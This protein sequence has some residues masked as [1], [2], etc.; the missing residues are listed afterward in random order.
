MIGKT[1][2]Q[3]G[4]LLLL[5]AMGLAV[6]GVAINSASAVAQEV[7]KGSSTLKVAPL[8]TDITVDPG[9]TKTVKITITNPTDRDLRVR[10]VQN[11]FVAEGENGAPAFMLNE[12]EAASKYSLKKYLSPLDNIDLPASETVTLDVQLVIPANADAG[13]YFGAIRFEPVDAATGGQVNLNT[14]IASLIL[15]R[16]SGDAPERL[17]LTDFEVQQRGRT[18]KWFTTDDNLSTLVRFENGGA[19]QLGPIG[20]ISIMKGDDVA[21]EHNFNQGEQTD[22]ILPDSAR[23]WSVPVDEVGGFGKY[24]AT[25][26]FSY[27]SKNE[28]VEIDYSFWIIPRTVIISVVVGVIVLLAAVVGVIAYIRSRGER[29]RSKRPRGRR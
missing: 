20:K 27:G 8:R 23:R 3:R 28:T 12:G 6:L 17:S 11:D 29:S 15:L 5:A 13:G 24:T 19:V 10:P 1:L 22:V 26:T 16:V 14:S 7:N 2:L 18:S 4:R 9:D 25:A 21:F